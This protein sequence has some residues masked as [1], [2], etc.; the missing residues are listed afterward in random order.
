VST[1]R[2]AGYIE[3][4]S[5]MPEGL[6]TGLDDVQLTELVRYVQSVK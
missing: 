4:R 3:G 1:L 6:T 5:A 2:S